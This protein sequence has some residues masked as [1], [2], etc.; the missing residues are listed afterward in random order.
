MFLKNEFA[1]RAAVEV[2][3]NIYRIHEKYIISNNL[4]VGFEEPTTRAPP[5]RLVYTMQV[6]LLQLAEGFTAPDTNSEDFDQ[7]ANTVTGAFRG[8]LEHLPGF[9]SLDV[10]DFQ[11]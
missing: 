9:S 7:L 8:P 1:S 11:E 5:P 4:D 6:K 10:M 2:S 3:I